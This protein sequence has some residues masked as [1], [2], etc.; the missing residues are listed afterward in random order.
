MP[1]ISL[2]LATYN[3]SHLLRGA[4]DAIAAQEDPGVPVTIIVADNGSTDLTRAVFREVSCHARRFDW[5]YLHE[6]RPGKSFAVNAALAR[7]T[8]D[9]LVFTDDDVRPERR[10][11]A[12]LTDAFSTAQPDFVVGRIVPIWQA[13]PP[14]WLT[15]SL[16]GVLGVP[17]NGAVPCAIALGENDHVMPIGANMAVQ[18]RIVDRLGGLRVDLG[19]MRGTLRT[20]EDHD[21]FLR[22][23]HGGCRGVYAPDAAVGHIVPQ[24]RLVRPYFRHWFH[25]NGRDVATLEA[26]YPAHAAI[27]LGVPRYRW[28]E[29][30]RHAARL[31]R[32]L[33]TFNP[34]MR[35]RSLVRLLWFA[36]YVREKWFG[37][38][39]QGP[40][41]HP[42]S[43]GRPWRETRH[44]HVAGPRPRDFGR[45]SSAARP[46][47]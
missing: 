11:L 32:S 33:A 35:F 47:R 29:A 24:G 25:Q 10:W 17:D 1:S 27:L 37:A 13:A 34:E 6:P 44:F 18:R 14:A 3:R 40:A 19:K 39:D 5:L 30:A 8:G 4:L 2:I 16:Y 42:V 31:L 22:L 46:W 20:G 45:T 36:G 7:A 26:S 28:R 21:F 12:S 9:W 38:L 41:G 15:P 43:S 23:L